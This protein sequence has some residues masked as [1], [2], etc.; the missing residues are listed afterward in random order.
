MCGRFVLHHEIDSLCENLSVEQSRFEIGP[1]YNIAPTQLVAVVLAGK[2]GQGRALDAHRWGLIP[3]WSKDPKIGSRMINA[4]AET[5]A[6]KPAFRAALR[7]RRCLIPTSGYYEWQ[8]TDDGKIPHYLHMADNRPF[9]MAGLWEEWT[10]P[11]EE[12]VRSCA[13]ITTE[14][15]AFAAQIHHRMPVILD[16]TGQAAWFDYSLKNPAHIT[17][18]LVPLKTPKAEEIANTVPHSEGF[19][20]CRMI[21][22]IS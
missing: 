2:E 20:A 19:R 18:P 9:A 14:A 11:D 13:I 10:S 4:R 6:E 1:R 16:E 7:Y 15:N 21:S 3:F 17:A 5:V 12:I 8:K 22:A